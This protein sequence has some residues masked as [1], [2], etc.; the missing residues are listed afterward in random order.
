MEAEGYDPEA[1]ETALRR[2][3]LIGL[4]MTSQQRILIAGCGFGFLVERFH[5]AGFPNVWGVDQS[6]HIA[7]NKATHVDG[8]VLMVA[9]DIRGGA[10]VRNALRTLTGANTF[11]WIV[12][13][14]VLESYDDAELP[15]LLNAAESVLANGRPLSS[16]VHIVYEPPFNEAPNVFNEKTLEQW[17]TLRPSHTWMSVNRRYQGAL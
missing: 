7:A 10:R 2:N 9:D 13:E 15:A 4:G 14:S 16:I 6:A 1:S 12:T 5:V 8:S 17:N 3:A 11:D